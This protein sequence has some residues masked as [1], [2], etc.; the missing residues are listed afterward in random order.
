MKDEKPYVY[1]DDEERVKKNKKQL[2]Y[3]Y[4]DD[5]DEKPKKK[6]SGKSRSEASAYDEP[7]RKAEK[8]SSINAA[9][10]YVDEEP[11]KKAAKKKKKKSANGKK[12]AGKPVKRQSR[13]GLVAL[14]LLLVLVL[15]AGF[16]FVDYTNLYNFGIIDEITG[17]PFGEKKNTQKTAASNRNEEPGEN[18]FARIEE[19]K[20][21]DGLVMSMGGTV[22]ADADL[23]VT[24]GLDA[25]WINILLLGADARVS[26][27]PC[28]TDTMM[29]C[30]INTRTGKIKLTSIMRDLAVNIAGH[31]TRLNSAYF[32]GGADLA[33]STINELF[34]MNIRDY[35]YVD[36]NGFASIAE[37]LGGIDINISENEMKWINHNVA[38]QYKILIRQGKMEYED[39][40][41]LYYDTE[42][43]TYGVNIHL[44]G[45]Q[46]LGYA[47]IR[48]LDG[49]DYERTRR[50]RDVLN[51]LLKKLQ[52]M[53]S[54]G[55]LTLANDNLNYCRTNLNTPTIVSL[56]N[57]VLNSSDFSGAEEL[58]LPI[59]GTYKD[60][61]R[62]NESML[63]D[64]DREANQR[65]LYEFIYS[66]ND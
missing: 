47:R 38:E 65:A 29:I 30:S 23:N 11:V 8:R 34:G 9:Y 58:R 56:A 60:E 1:V 51:K 20:D 50:Q 28:R 21:D 16:V 27:E 32:Y 59:Q 14:I 40:E 49:G 62:N 17:W 13:S 46:T 22:K 54:A 25:E 24:E 57:V 15:A 26:T 52:G 53:S 63:Y 18:I 48:K 44:D 5:E 31:N 3:E 12:K 19:E 55:L 7:V 43:K 6:K 42:L 61:A 10:E 45:M 35:V 64:M 2:A 4:V 66:G 37:D 33:M 36:F 39:A 41:K